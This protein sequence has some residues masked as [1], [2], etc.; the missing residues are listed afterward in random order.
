MFLPNAHSVYRIQNQLNFLIC[1]NL[2]LIP[3]MIFM[4]WATKCIE[5]QYQI[6]V[7]SFR[8]L[9]LL[10]KPRCPFTQNEPTF[11]TD[12]TKVRNKKILPNPKISVLTQLLIIQFEKALQIK[13]SLEWA[14][15]YV[16]QNIIIFIIFSPF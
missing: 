12:C 8:I 10:V 4:N 1:Y 2:Y 16:V 14:E 6:A 13:G 9:L 7:G 5:Q 11:R 15:R 3:V